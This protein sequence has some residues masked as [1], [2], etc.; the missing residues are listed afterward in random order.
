MGTYGYLVERLNYFGV[1]YIHVIE[2]A[3][4][5]SREE[6]PGFSLQRLRRMFRGLYMANNGYDLDLALRARRED[7]ADLICF[8]RPFIANPDLVERLRTGAPLAE[9]PKETWYG[10]GAHGYTDYPTLAETRARAAE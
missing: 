3:T 8:G 2:G 1:V 4:Q 7:L 6:P 9:A 10:G 5:G